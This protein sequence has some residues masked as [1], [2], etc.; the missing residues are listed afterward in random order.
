MNPISATAKSRAVS[1]ETAGSDPAGSGGLYDWGR[2][3]GVVTQLI[4][5]FETLR[6]ENATLHDEL[7]KQ[8]N[9]TRTLEA[10]VLELNQRRQD[11]TKRIDDLV[12]QIDYID[13][14][15]GEPRG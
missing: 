9:R 2:L 8:R 1:Q 7:A 15:M 14:Q 12:A 5:R 4:E 10:Q 6:R 11:V 13:A 3:E